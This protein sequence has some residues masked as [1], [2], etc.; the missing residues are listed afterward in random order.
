MTLTCPEC[1]MEIRMGKKVYFLR[2]KSY[3]PV[4]V[5]DNKNLY[6]Q[7]KVKREGDDR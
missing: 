7:W 3:H 4:C 6:A 5:M 2:G 1:G